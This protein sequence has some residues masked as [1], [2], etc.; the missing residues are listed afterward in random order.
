VHLVK[1]VGEFLR[2]AEILGESPGKRQAAQKPLQTIGDQ[3]T[4]PI[5]WILQL[6]WNRRA[7]KKHK[8]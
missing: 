4:E 1:F 3:I 6:K 7:D 2:I 8:L 5:E